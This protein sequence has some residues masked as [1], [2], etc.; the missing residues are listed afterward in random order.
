[1]GGLFKHGH[2]V[3]PP[4]LRNIVGRPIIFW[5]LD[6][7]TLGPRDTVWIGLPKEVDEYFALSKQ[8]STSVDLCRY[9]WVRGEYV[10]GSGSFVGGSLQC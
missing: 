10:G 2:S 1:M 7:L 5:L 3:V 9:L 6:H 4:P 8:V